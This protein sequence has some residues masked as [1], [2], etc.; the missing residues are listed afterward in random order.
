MALDQ[1]HVEEE[2][3]TGEKEMTFLEHLEE[4]RWHLIRSAI[5]IFVFMIIAWIIK[6]W[7]YSTVVMGP[8]KVD[9]WTYRKMCEI[10]Q[11]LHI[12]SLCLKELNFEVQ[13]RQITGQF[14]LAITSSAVIG[15]ILAF[16][17]LI[18]EIWRFI[19]PGLRAVERRAA[20]GVVFVV[21]LL[22]LTGVAFG[23]YI[24]TPFA[25][26][27]MV[28]FQLD[29]EII[30]QY[31]IRNYLSIL[32]TLTL[33][34]GLMFQ[35]PVIIVFLTQIGLITPQFLKQ[36]RRHAVVVL[37]VIAAVITPSPDMISQIIVAVPLYILYEIS[38]LASY[39]FYNKRQ[40]ELQD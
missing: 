11:F 16:P 6:E 3:F 17:Y 22:F 13:N 2:E 20:R 36:Y 32:T 19:K 10:G 39:R 38:I 27:F 12:D 26:Q 30:N 37:L 24:V 15:L 35:L 25:I 40:K 33:A 28:N 23:Y 8:S 7:I 9:F 31:D 14:M 34:C 29:P 5:A 21:S 1:T 4:L 18:W